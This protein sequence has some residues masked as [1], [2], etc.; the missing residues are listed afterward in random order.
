MERDSISINE[1]NA[2]DAAWKAAGMPSSGLR[3]CGHRIYG[4]RTRTLLEVPGDY[5][6]PRYELQDGRFL[7]STGPT[8]EEWQLAQEQLT[9]F[10]EARE[11]YDWATGH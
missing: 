10:H 6:A 3:I 4:N 2:I 11:L 8:L 7:H 9:E 5:F 1:A